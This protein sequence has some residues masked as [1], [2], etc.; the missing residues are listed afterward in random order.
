MQ[1]PSRS[2]QRYLTVPSSRET[3]LRATVGRCNGKLLAELF[4]QRLGEI[5]HLRKVGRALMEPGEH[6]LAAEGRLA[7]RAQR[8]RCLLLGHGFDIGHRHPHSLRVMRRCKSR[9]SRWRCGRAC[10]SSTVADGTGQ[11]KGIVSKVQVRAEKRIRHPL[12]FL[13][14]HR[15]GGVNERPAAPDIA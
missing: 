1:L 12:V 9:P 4:S 13:G 10:V 2:S 15:A 6:L 7:H 3:C 11:R 8:G 14:K 5:V